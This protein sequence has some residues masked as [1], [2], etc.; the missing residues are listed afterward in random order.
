VT[1]KAGS[2]SIRRGARVRLKGR[3]ASTARNH[4]SHA[5]V[6]VKRRRHWRTVRRTPIKH[7]SY[8]TKVRM[9][10]RH[11]DSVRVRVKVRGLGSSRQLVLRLHR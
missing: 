10:A 9:R 2:R 7:G 1:L 3:I 6:Q 8:A 4:G 5:L 11:H